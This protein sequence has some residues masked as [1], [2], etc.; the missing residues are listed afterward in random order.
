MRPGGRFHGLRFQSF[1]RPGNPS[2]SV[3]NATPAI[4]LG[5]ILLGAACAH[6]S[7]AER[8]TVELRP[9]EGV[10]CA[11]LTTPRPWTVPSDVPNNDS[12]LLRAGGFHRA[13][14]DF[15]FRQGEKLLVSIFTGSRIN[16]C[17]PDKYAVIQQNSKLAL[18]PATEVEW[19]SGR[20]L[21]R[22]ERHVGGEAANGQPFPMPAV[23]SPRPGVLVGARRHID[24]LVDRS[25]I[26]CALYLGRYGQLPRP[27]RC[28]SIQS[29]RCSLFYRSL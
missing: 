17:S 10:T 9:G 12:G 29:T 5:L 2:R 11:E 28:L 16:L 23:P 1:K 6:L 26:H 8:I 4:S 18:T 14:A 27:I 7:A 20:V 13:G 22:F 25:G 24:S 21:Q 3:N 15:E 19:Q